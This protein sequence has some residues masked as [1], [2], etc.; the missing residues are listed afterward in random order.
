MIK[1]GNDP[2]FTGLGDK[3]AQ[4][5]NPQFDKQYAITF[6]DIGIITPYDG[7]KK[8]LQKMLKEEGLQIRVDTVDGFQGMERQLDW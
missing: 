5:N 4:E 8:L 1:R 7:Q 2:R 6:G 3:N